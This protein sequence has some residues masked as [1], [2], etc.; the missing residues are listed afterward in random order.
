MA[1]G[2]EELFALHCKAYGLT[3]V[4]EHRVVPTRRWRF[5]YAFPDALLA[6]E[7]QGGTWI[8][9]GHSRGKGIERD[10]EKA[11]EAMVLGWRVLHVTTDQV[12]NGQAISWV[13]KLLN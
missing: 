4:R 10:C 11:A 6:V 3:P 8:N 2:L 12:R 7:I 1:S 9:G 5:D 13:V